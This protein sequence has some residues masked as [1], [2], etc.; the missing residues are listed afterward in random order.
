MCIR[1]RYNVYPDSVDEHIR[2]CERIGEEK[3]AKCMF[4]IAENTNFYLHSR[5]EKNNYMRQECFVVG[6][7]HITEETTAQLKA[8]N[9]T[10]TKKVS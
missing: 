9:L 8:K 1:D 2:G 10:E 4:R 5:L 3:A 6:A 7:L